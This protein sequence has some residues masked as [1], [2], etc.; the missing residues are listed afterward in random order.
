MLCGQSLTVALPS[1]DAT[2]RVEYTDGVSGV[3]LCWE[4]DDK[5]AL[6]TTT[7]DYV[8]DFLYASVA[9]NGIAKFTS[10]SS[11]VT[12][13]DGSNYIAIFPAIE[14]ATTIDDYDTAFAELLANQTQTGN[15]DSHHLNNAQRME[16]EFTYN[17]LD[18]STLT[19]EHKM[20][21]VRIAF[22]YE[23]SIP[24][25]VV[26]NDGDNRNYTLNFEEATEATIYTSYF[27]IE[28]N[29]EGDSR[30]L[31][32]EIHSSDSSVP[33]SYFTAIS[34]AT[35]NTGVQYRLTLAL[36]NLC[37]GISTKEEL[38]AFQES[39]NSGNVDINAV[40]LADIDLNGEEWIP[41]G[42]SETAYSGTFNGGGYTINNLT[43]NSTN[44][45]QGLF[46]YINGGS[47]SNL[48][49]ENSQVQGGSYTG[50]ICGYS[51]GTISSCGIVDGSVSGSGFYVGGV[52]G[53]TS[54]SLTSCYN[55]GSVSGSSSVGGVVGGAWS[56]S[57]SSSLVACYNTGS[58]SGSSS[59]GGVVGSSSFSL[60]AC[61]YISGIEYTYGTRVSTLAE[62]NGVVATMNN[63]AGSN[64]FTTNSDNI[65]PSLFDE[66]I[67][68]EDRVYIENM[69]ISTVEELKTFQDLVN[70]G[71]SPSVAT[72]TANIDL[73]GEKWMPI[74]S[75]SNKYSGTFNGGD[76]TISNFIINSTNDYQGLFGYVSNG[77]ISNLIVEN[78]QVQGGSY[79]GAICGYAYSNSAI[80]SCGVVGGSVSGSGDYV[81]GVVGRASSLTTCYN[82]GLV[83]SSGDYVG[84]VVGCTYSSSLTDCYNIGSVSGI[85][86]Y[87]GGVVGSVSSSSSFTNC[88][89]TGS[90]SGGGSRVG[91][92]V[93]YSTYSS[94]FTS[95]YNTGSVSGGGS[96]IGGVVGYSSSSF[97][98]CYNTATV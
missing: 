59:V 82:T 70:F 45:Y 42:T 23:D 8:A 75:L 68:Y 38:I 80:S 60:T 35:Y 40:L 95:C 14:G 83:S 85:G 3:D 6:Y 32:F 55:T 43:I 34:S 74:G 86:D 73:N 78:P 47:I 97:T 90:V 76:H 11:Q 98:N 91:G 96:C 18:D 94:S 58:V 20:A 48:I 71:W 79:T 7:G 93:G 25:K 49:I 9:S 88:Y 12:L 53:Y 51:S 56:F 16:A 29:L 65:L 89:N 87:V 67:T 26:F 24:S 19:F 54:S 1:D 2:T 36:S 41:I 5:F 10:T 28:P 37:T 22:G 44:D 33:T 62:L 13:T 63:A 64:C 50:A 4:E 15:S 66:H 77:R 27:V 92:V 30:L 57:P 21:S 39:V 46:G 69:N 61:Y 72:L 81:G 52:V 17:A 84:G 31:T